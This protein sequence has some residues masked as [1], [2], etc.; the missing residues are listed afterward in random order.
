MRPEIACGP[1]DRILAVTLGDG[2]GQKRSQEWKIQ[3]F[4]VEQGITSRSGR[5]F[6][7]QLSLAQRHDC[8]TG[9]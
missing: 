8:V 4:R 7:S 5:V 3:S 2:P 6:E 1:E 9:A